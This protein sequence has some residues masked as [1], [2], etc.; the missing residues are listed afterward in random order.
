IE[1]ESRRLTQLINNILDFSRIGSGRKTFNF[2]KANIVELIKESLKTFEIIQK[3][4]GFTITLEMPEEA[5]PAIS[6]D[7]DTIVQAFMNLIDNAIKYSG[8]CKE[9]RVRLGCQ[10]QYITI[11]VIDYGIGI[12]RNDHT[13][14]FEKFYRVSTGLVHDVKGS[15]L[16]LSIVKHIVEAHKGKVTVT[17]TPGKGSTFTIHLPIADNLNTST[18]V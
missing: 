16:G 4:R 10:D 9:I 13:K 12:P 14:I 5:L 8:S 17:S 15:G 1:A 6:I 11:S 3:Q 7:S 2:E 18:R